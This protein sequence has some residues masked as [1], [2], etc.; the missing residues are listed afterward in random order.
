MLEFA[1]V[2]MDNGEM[3]NGKKIGELTEFIIN[4][5]S[6]E[7]LTHDEAQIVLERTRSIIGEFS[8]IQ[9]IGKK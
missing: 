2:Q 5:F 3:L 9:S 1:S 4:K 6:E 7:N 8:K